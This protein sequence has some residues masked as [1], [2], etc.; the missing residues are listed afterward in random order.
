HSNI[1]VSIS[2][3]NLEPFERIM[4]KHKQKFIVLGNT[5]KDIYKINDLIECRSV[6]LRDMWES[7]FD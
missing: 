5:T 2:A 6:E 4:M 1:V 7:A 3:G